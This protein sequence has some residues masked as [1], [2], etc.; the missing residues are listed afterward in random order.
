MFLGQPSTPSVQASEKLQQQ[1]GSDGDVG[2]PSTDQDSG[3]HDTQKDENFS[4]SGYGSHSSTVSEG[5]SNVG[6]HGSSSQ[7]EETRP[8]PLL[9]DL[10]GRWPVKKQLRVIDRPIPQPAKDKFLDWRILFNDKLSHLASSA[11]PTS[12]EVP[13]TMKLLYL[14]T[15][16]TDANYTWCSFAIRGLLSASNRSSR[17]TMSEK[18][19]AVNLFPKSSRKV[20]DSSEEKGYSVCERAGSP[21]HVVVSR[22]MS[23]R[24]KTRS[25]G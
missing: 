25:R 8:R 12:W 20:Q 3:A 4:D 10:R 19:W 1:R 15:K 11:A 22:C 13:T 21:R 17:K 7:C 6:S 14:G 23:A 9:L 5:T 2:R 24:D 18:I 16:D